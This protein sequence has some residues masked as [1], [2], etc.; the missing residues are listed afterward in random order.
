MSRYNSEKNYKTLQNF[1]KLKISN[2]TQMQEAIKLLEALREFDETA[3]FPHYKNAN[4][5]LDLSKLS[6][7]L[8]RRKRKRK[9]EVNELNHASMAAAERWS[10]GFHR[11][12]KKA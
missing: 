8:S 6:T 9:R 7:N 3:N 5:R 10:K 4:G 1:Q 12:S 2:I 11:N